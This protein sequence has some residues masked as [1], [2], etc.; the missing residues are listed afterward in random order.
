MIKEGFG[1]GIGS[2]MARNMFD[3]TSNSNSKVASSPVPESE[4]EIPDTFQQC[5]DKTG[6]NYETRGHLE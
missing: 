2:T 1:F 6:G 3:T 4:K 5:M